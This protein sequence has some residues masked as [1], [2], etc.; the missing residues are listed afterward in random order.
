MAAFIVGFTSFAC[1]YRFGLLLIL[2]YYSSSKLT[3]VREDVKSKLEESHTEGGQRNWVQVLSC[4]FFA[5]LVAIAFYVIVGED[6]HV[7]YNGISA[8]DQMSRVTFMDR[9]YT[10]HRQEAATLLWTMYV[11]H[12]SCAAADT[13]ASEVGI[14]SKEK[15]RLITALLLREVPHGTNGG[16]SWLGTIASAAGGSFIG[17]CFWVL[18]RVSYFVPPVSAHNNIHVGSQYPMIFVG[19]IAGVVGSIVDS[20]LGGSLQATYYSNERKCIVKNRRGIVCNGDSCTLDTSVVHVC[21]F[22]L[23]SNEA[24]NWLS[25]VIT[26]LLSVLFAPWIFCIA[27]PN[28]CAHVPFVVVRW[29]PFTF[30][31]VAASWLLPAFICF[32]YMAQSPRSPRSLQ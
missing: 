20:V 9:E 10:F 2:F 5:T 29:V 18:S 7:S 13:W 4:S 32:F 12:Y 21:G 1:S 14:L 25:T 27:D 24:V 26:M 3:K 28:Q 17:F 11:A 23:L 22:D 19:F 31:F 6:C 16:V 15:P 30:V 8:S